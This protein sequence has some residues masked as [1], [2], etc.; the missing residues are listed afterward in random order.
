[1]ISVPIHGEVAFSIEDHVVVDSDLG[2]CDDRR[3]TLAVKEMGPAPLRDSVSD[4]LFGASNKWDR[5]KPRPTSSLAFSTR[6]TV[7]DGRSLADTV[8]AHVGRA[9]VAVIALRSVC[10]RDE[11]ARA[12]G[13]EVFR[14]IVLIVAVFGALAF[15]LAF[16]RD[17]DAAKAIEVAVRS[18]FDGEGVTSA[19]RVVAGVIGAGVLVIAH[20]AFA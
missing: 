4:T 14:A 18:V 6:R 2:L 9:F 11:L 3:W 17:T 7:F 20:N 10:H 8:G 13:A 16:P 12:I 19:V 5:T 15:R 1:V